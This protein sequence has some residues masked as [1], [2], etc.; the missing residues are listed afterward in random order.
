[1]EATNGKRIPFSVLAT[2]TPKL[3]YGVGSRQYLCIYNNTSGN[4]QIGSSG[5]MSNG[6]IVPTNT[7]FHDLFSSDEWW[8]IASSGSG[9]VSG[10]AVI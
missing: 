8:V 2:T 10:F 1:M 4:I 5:T 7:A 3:L 9:T 6:L